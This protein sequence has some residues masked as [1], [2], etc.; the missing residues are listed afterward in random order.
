MRNAGS[1]LP[2]A[3]ATRREEGSG[4]GTGVWT[5]GPGDWMGRELRGAPQTGRVEN[6]R[7]QAPVPIAAPWGEAGRPPA[8]R[9]AFC[10][11]WGLFWRLSLDWRVCCCCVDPSTPELGPLQ[12]NQLLKR[13]QELYKLERC[14]STLQASWVEW[15]GLPK[16][17]FYSGFLLNLWK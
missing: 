5:T 9:D 8:R 15:L 14:S 3:S 2:A 13:Q 1:S 7:F 6:L 16:S 17:H 10:D 4:P 11:I 12:G